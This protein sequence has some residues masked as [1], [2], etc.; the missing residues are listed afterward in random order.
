MCVRVIKDPFVR[1]F[2]HLIC[3]GHSDL[4]MV[5]STGDQLTGCLSSSSN[6]PGEIR[7]GLSFQYHPGLPFRTLILGTSTPVIARAKLKPRAGDLPWNFTSR[8][9][10]PSPPRRDRSDDDM[11]SLVDHKEVGFGYISESMYHMRRQAYSKELP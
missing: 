1:S 6:R 2:P 7:G 8:S 3:P 4:Q 5:V 11:D 9:T 10:P